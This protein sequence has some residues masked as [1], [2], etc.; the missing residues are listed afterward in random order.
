M[1]GMRRSGRTILILAALLI[2]F[3]GMIGHSAENSGRDARLHRLASERW[4]AWRTS[5]VTFPIGAWSYFQRFDGTKEEFET[6][7]DAGMTVVLP[8]FEQFDAA[9]STGLDVMLGHFV[10]LHED[11]ALLEKALTTPAPGDRRVVGYMLEDEPFVEEY[12][13]LGRTVERIYERDRRGAIPIIDFRPNWAV[14]YERWNMTYETYFDR[15]IEEIHPCVLLNCHYAIMNDGSTRPVFYA[16]IEWFRRR[17]L[18]L[19]IGLMGFA[20]V[21]RHNPPNRPEQDYREPSESDLRWTVYTYLAYGAQGIWYYNWRIDDSGDFGTALVDY[22]SGEP[23]HLYPMVADLNRELHVIGPHLMKLGSL[24]VY[25]TNAE[26]PPGT[27]RLYEGYVRGMHGFSGDDFIIGEFEN[28]DDPGDESVYVMIVNKRHAKDT[29]SAELKAACS[30]SV[31][32]DYPAVRC[33]NPDNGAWKLTEDGGSY[34]LEL[35]GGQ[36]ALLRLGKR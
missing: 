23:T 2:P 18:E 29:A 5:R 12:A 21:T 28:I 17:A 3:T 4:H 31:Y 25:H 8:T 1:K 9:A 7:R 36:G 16:N 20:L 34:R 35:N 27:T 22:K 13:S 33:L 6:Y 14:P 11:D 24:G 32:P 30:F 19:D 26:V 15:F 10:K